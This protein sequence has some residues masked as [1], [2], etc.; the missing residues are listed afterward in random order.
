MQQSVCGCLYCDTLILVKPEGNKQLNYSVKD[1]L[2][3]QNIRASCASVL[4]NIVTG[5]VFIQE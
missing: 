2:I 3:P 5:V 4:S 1:S